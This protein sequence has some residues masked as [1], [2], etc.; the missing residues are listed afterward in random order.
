MLNK[1]VCERNKAVKVGI[2]FVDELEYGAAIFFLDFF[3]GG[4]MLYRKI[5]LAHY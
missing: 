2:C 1:L 4:I 3:L 5:I